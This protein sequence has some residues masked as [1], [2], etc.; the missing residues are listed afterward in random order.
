VRCHVHL[1]AQTIHCFGLRRSQP[2][3]QP[4]LVTYHA[5]SLITHFAGYRRRIAVANSAY[6]G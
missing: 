3:H 4:L 5:N 2:D 6:A 1:R